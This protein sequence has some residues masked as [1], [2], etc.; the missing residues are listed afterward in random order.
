[1]KIHRGGRIE[2]GLRVFGVFQASST[3]ARFAHRPFRSEVRSLDLDPS[4]EVGSSRRSEVVPSCS[5][6]WARRRPG[7]GGS[8]VGAV[9]G[10]ADLGHESAR[11]ACHA[12]PCWTSGS[13]SRIETGCPSAGRLDVGWS[14]PETAVPPGEKQ[15]ARDEVGTEGEDQELPDAEHRD[16]RFANAT[17]PCGGGGTRGMLGLR[18]DNRVPVHPDRR[19]AM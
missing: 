1:M 14:S 18:H 19:E 2:V 5:S 8:H 13:D 16:L 17:I 9:R 3:L 6:T 11:G 10:V 7:R 12:G 15:H 4:S